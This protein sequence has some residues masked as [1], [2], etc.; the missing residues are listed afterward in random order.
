MK[1]KALLIFCLLLSSCGSGGS[2][3]KDYNIKLFVVNIP[4]NFAEE[5]RNGIHR[6][7]DNAEIPLVTDLYCVSW[8]KTYGIGEKRKALIQLRNEFGSGHFIV[9][10]FGTQFDGVQ[11]GSSSISV[12]VVGRLT[13]S[14]EQAA[15]EIGHQ[16]GAS[17][18]FD[19]CN[20][21]GYRRCGYPAE[22]NL[23]AIKEMQ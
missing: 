14:E 2:G 10:K 21:M 3:N 19:N 16:F 4:C 11:I 5:I 13:D 6:K 7:F 9:P 18:D 12:G 22:F 20:I 17:H 8:D 23:K 1:N 15:H